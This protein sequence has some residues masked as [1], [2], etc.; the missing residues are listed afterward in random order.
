MRCK[1]C[2]Y[3]LAKLTTHRCPE[4]GRVFDP[5][6]PST[7]SSGRSTSLRRWFVNP[8]ARAVLYAPIMVWLYWVVRALL[9]GPSEGLFND[10]SSSVS[11][12]FILMVFYW[13]LTPLSMVALYGLFV[14]MEVTRQSRAERN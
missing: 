7:Y 2:H 11:V 10:L 3:P 5:D 4:C 6:D 12:G 8:A 9:V 14:L 1:T 13:W